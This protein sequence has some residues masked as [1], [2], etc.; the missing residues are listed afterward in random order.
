MYIVYAH[1]YMYIQCTIY[2]VLQGLTSAESMATVQVAR[3]FI[4]RVQKFVQAQSTLGS[5]TSPLYCLPS[6][7]P[8]PVNVVRAAENAVVYL[9]LRNCHRLRVLQVEWV[10]FGSTGRKSYGTSRARA[11]AGKWPRRHLYIY[12]PTSLAFLFQDMY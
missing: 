11:L 10:A 9:S 1:I 5:Y 7:L 6:P 12:R 8:L 2:Q 4:P 3:D